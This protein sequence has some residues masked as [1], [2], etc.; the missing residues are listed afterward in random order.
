[1]RSIG[2]AISIAAPVSDAIKPNMA[3]TG[4]NIPVRLANVKATSA[5]ESAYAI[6]DRSLA[7]KFSVNILTMIVNDQNT[8][9]RARNKMEKGRL[10]KNPILNKN[11]A[12]ISFRFHRRLLTR[13][14]STPR[15]KK[16]VL[17]SSPLSVEATNERSLPPLTNGNFVRAEGLRNCCGNVGTTRLPE[18]DKL[19]GQVGI[20]LLVWANGFS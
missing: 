7:T 8:R 15:E 3:K 11:R 12:N 2:S 13:T 9:D 16:G 14:D 6:E 20:I 18:V 17:A 10:I 5:L 19:S 1:M 4:K